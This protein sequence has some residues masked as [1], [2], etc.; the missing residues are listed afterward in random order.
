MAEK[1]PYPSGA[2]RA[3]EEIGAVDVADIRS[4]DLLKG[5][6]FEVEIQDGWF[7][8]SLFHDWAKRGKG[9]DGVGESVGLTA[10]VALAIEDAVG[11]TAAAAIVEDITS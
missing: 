5:S 10:A 7:H 11:L 6:G 8:V 9:P 2:L 4:W 1:E 3:A